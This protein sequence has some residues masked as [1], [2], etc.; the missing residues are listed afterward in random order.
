MKRAMTMLCAALVAAAA[1][2]A[3]L[4]GP[5]PTL[6]EKVV[7]IDAGRKVAK[8]AD[9]TRVQ[10]LLSQMAERY[11]TTEAAV[12]D[13]AV[14]CATLLRDKYGV[15]ITLQALLEDLNRVAYAGKKP[16]ALGVIAAA[17][18]QQR[19]AGKDAASAVAAIN[20]DLAKAKK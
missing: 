16:E 13:T 8:Q 12:G 10:S 2:A 11:A 18:A 3:E 9:V 19:N 4:Y 1:Q 20:A 6:A 15:P 17:Y 7:R 5:N 14:A